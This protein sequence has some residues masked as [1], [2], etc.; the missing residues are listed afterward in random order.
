MEPGALVI[1]LAGLFGLFV[2]LFAGWLVWAPLP[3]TEA[4]VTRPMVTVEQPA[5]EKTL[6]EREMD[7][8]G[9]QAWRNWA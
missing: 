5:E 3:P 7:E 9:E 8:T 2:G 6:A 4:P 1:F